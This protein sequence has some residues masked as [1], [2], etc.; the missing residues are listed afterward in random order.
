M[1]SLREKLK[2]E[3]ALVL[4]VFIL[5]LFGC[6][7][8]Q[9]ADYIISN[10]LVIDGSTEPAFEG[11]VVVIGDEIVFVGKEHNY[12][13]DNTIDGSGKYITPGFIDPH[14]HALDDLSTTAN[15]RNSNLPF[16]FQGITTV[17]NGSDGGS[18]VDIGE[19]LALWE[20]QGI[21]TNAA[22]M[23]G[24]RS[25]RRLVMSMSDKEPTEE[26]LTNMKTLVHRG[27]QD[28]ALGFSSGLY[29]APASFAKTV[30]QG[31]V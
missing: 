17:V 24:H 18:V 11:D 21:G 28:G 23:V 12:S 10:A 25:I 15:N 4:V 3:F 1:K 16:L 2:L 30:W 8:S 20:K 19:R 27:M 22:I 31:T 9:P 14:T 26:E 29:Y 13:S 7:S 5:L 6:N